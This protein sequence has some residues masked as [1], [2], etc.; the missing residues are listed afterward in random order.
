MTVLVLMLIAGM[1]LIVALVTAALVVHHA[2]RKTFK[3]LNPAW[4]WF[5]G[6]PI[7]DGQSRTNATWT[8]RS[9]G[10]KPV[11]HSSGHAVAWHHLPRLHRAGIRI[12]ASV[13]FVAMAYGLVTALALTLASLSIAAACGLLVLAWHVYYRIRYWRHERHHVRPLER[14]IIAKNLPEPVSLEVER[15]GD[16]VKSVAIDWAP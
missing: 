10:P 12:G 5:T 4:W 1:A 3:A 9:H 14:T 16:T 2:L 8:M 13:A 15:D 7:G 6:L 11:L